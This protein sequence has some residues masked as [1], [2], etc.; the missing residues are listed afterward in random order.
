MKQQEYIHVRIDAPIYTKKLILETAILST[1]LIKDIENFNRINSEKQLKFKEFGQN[2][3]HIS[4]LINKFY[5]ELPKIKTKKTTQIKE[6]RPKFP[7]KPT[8]TPIKTDL[9]GLNQE[10]R[11]LEQKIKNLSL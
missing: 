7:K 6:I 9:T 4:S 10:I 5:R 3:R 2:K 8:R 11:E 1:E